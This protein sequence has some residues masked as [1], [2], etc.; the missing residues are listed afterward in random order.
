MYYISIVL[1]VI[2]FTFLTNFLV[3]K[4]I[5]YITNCKAKKLY[6]N[7]DCQA[8]SLDIYNSMKGE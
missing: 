3:D 6:K 8:K 1:F 7:I 5:V 2:A 4:L